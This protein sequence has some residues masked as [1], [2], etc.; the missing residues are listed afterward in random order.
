[1]SQGEGA[2]SPSIWASESTPAQHA[3]VE[4]CHTHPL[5]KGSW[6]GHGTPH[7]A[8]QLHGTSFVQHDIWRHQHPSHCLNASFLVFQRTFGIGATL[9]Q[10]GGALGLA[11]DL[12]R[13]LILDFEDRWTKAQM[14]QNYGY[15][16]GLQS[17]DTC[18]F[19]PLSS[20]SLRDIYGAEFVTAY[21]EN[22]D[23]AALADKRR[24]THSD[25]IQFMVVQGINYE[26]K[27]PDRYKSLMSY[28]GVRSHEHVGGI[29]RDVYW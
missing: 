8:L 15:C 4:K 7:A 14:G 6:K 13:V 12:N 29:N 18:Y 2:T 24:Q 1:V 9:D 28:H 16:K 21:N 17:L 25:R 26:N 3:E 22:P 20:C 10:V 27:L 5:L 23:D 19:E 11:L